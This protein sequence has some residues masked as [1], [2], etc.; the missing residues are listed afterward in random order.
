M[1]V[2]ITGNPVLD[3]ASVRLALR[4]AEARQEAIARAAG[5]V[6]QVEGIRLRTWARR[7]RILLAR[8]VAQVARQA[9]Q[10]VASWSR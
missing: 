10:R 1:R 6:R 8:R 7:Q 9:R 4:L 3:A 5:L 2:P